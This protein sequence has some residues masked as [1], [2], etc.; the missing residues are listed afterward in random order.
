MFDT[1]SCCDFDYSCVTF[2]RSLDLGWES[3]EGKMSPGCACLNSE[4]KRNWIL[5]IVE[6]KKYLKYIGSTIMLYYI[7]VCIL[8]ALG[9]W[10][11][12][13]LAQ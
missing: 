3:F 8:E 13:G 11:F 1:Y 4:K 12:F 6:K 7:L 9:F 2:L 10:L 5:G